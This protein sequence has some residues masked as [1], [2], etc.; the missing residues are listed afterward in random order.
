M[1]LTPPFHV[2]RTRR[3]PIAC[4]PL[5]LCAAAMA[6]VVAV[7]GADARA[8]SAAAGPVFEVAA[9]RRNTSSSPAGAGSRMQPGGNYTATNLTLQRLIAIAYEVPADRVLGGPDW[10][11]DDR[12]DIAARADGNP[13]APD[14][15][16]LVRTLLRDR[17]GLVVRE[18]MREY[19]VYA[20]V[21]ARPDGS[22]GPRLW[23][24][25][26]DCTGRRTL[27]GAPTDLSVRP[28][29]RAPLIVEKDIGMFVGGDVPMSMLAQVLTFSAG[30]PVV[31]QTGESGRFDISLEWASRPDV[32]DGVQIFTAVQEQLGLKLEPSTAPIPVLV[33]DRIEMPTE[34]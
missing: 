20:L 17:F 22:L 28:V 9:I 11:D 8:Q 12:Y 26:S 5:V 34:D 29:C 32:G 24:S 19:P 14:V 27:S 13:G 25:E 30:R 31:D 6:G 16:P 10:V 4:A 2:E 15:A 33:I 1:R 7:A 21:K 18:E 23:A 3:R